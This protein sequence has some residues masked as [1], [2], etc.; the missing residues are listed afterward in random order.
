MSC[1]CVESAQWPPLGQ[2]RRDEPSWEFLPDLSP[3]WR[4]RKVNRCS[5]SSLLLF[6][7]PASET[8][9]VIIFIIVLV[10]VLMLSLFASRPRQDGRHGRPPRAAK[11]QT[12]PDPLT[13][14]AAYVSFMG[15]D[16]GLASECQRVARRRDDDQQRQWQQ[17][18]H[19]QQQVAAQ[20]TGP[21]TCKGCH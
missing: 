13:Y 2:P 18:H 5:S 4:S 14:W 12:S 11:T 15:A 6:G 1:L 9:E 8:F 10:V 3:G 21:P 17:H 19:H 16:G 7:R 20:F